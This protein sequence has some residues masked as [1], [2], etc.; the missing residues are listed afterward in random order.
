QPADVIRD[1][2]GGPGSRQPR[3]TDHGQPE[4]RPRERP[5]GHIEG[6][7]ENAVQ[8]NPLGVRWDRP[9]RYDPCT[10]SPGRITPPVRICARRPPRW[11][12]PALTPSRVSPS[13]WPQGSH[14]RIPR[15]PT[16][17]TVNSR[18]TSWLSGTPR[19]A[20]LR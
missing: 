9:G 13:R 6:A 17:P 3:R 16:A 18:P 14:R 5:D 7:V 10:G 12:N 19:V 11:T 20:M 2:H 4:Q 8:E 1:D 15:R